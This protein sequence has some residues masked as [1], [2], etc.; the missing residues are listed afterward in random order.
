[1]PTRQEILVLFMIIILATA[2]ISC[3]NGSISDYEKDILVTYDDIDKEQNE[4]SNKVRTEGATSYRSKTSFKGDR[5][6][7]Y[8]F[9]Y[10]SK[11]SSYYMRVKSYTKI[12][13]KKVSHSDFLKMIEKMNKKFS[14]SSRVELLPFENIPTY[15]D[16]S[17]FRVIM[18]D[19]LAYGNLLVFRYQ[20]YLFSVYFLGYCP[21]KTESFKLFFDPLFNEISEKIENRNR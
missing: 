8:N 7:Y 4:T 1:M 6:L 15:G 13:K 19:E 21:Y 17:F 12:T 20:N 9:Y 2:V 16:G 14:N 18:I 3:S 11:K 10:K 5:H